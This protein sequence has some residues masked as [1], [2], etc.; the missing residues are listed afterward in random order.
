MPTGTMCGKVPVPVHGFRC[1]EML[2]QIDRALFGVTPW[3]ARWGRLRPLVRIWR[4]GPLLIPPGVFDP[5]ATV[6]GVWLA[7]QLEAS[8]GEHWLEVGCGSGVVAL[9]LAGQGATVTAVDVDPRALGATR[10]NAR[11][12]GLEVEVRAS[13]LFGGL[14][15]R[16]FDRIACNLPFWP[17]EPDG[18]PW[19]RAM[20][21]GADFHLLQRF[22]RE[23]PAYAPR[24]WTVLSNAGGHA[25]AAR[26]ALGNPPIRKEAWVHGECLWLLE[27][28]A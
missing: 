21:A 13:D 26:A 10:F 28:Q 15:G 11:L 24:A 27:M 16:R 2:F 8:A 19:S 9:A 4:D 23:F 17:G 12:R 25:A 3:K 5:V 14:Q 7:D 20:R 22:R 6:A 18:S 1:P